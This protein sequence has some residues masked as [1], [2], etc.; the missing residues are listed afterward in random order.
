MVKE[1][2]TEEVSSEVGNSLVCSNKIMFSFIRNC[3]IPGAPG[4]L[5]WLSVPLNFNSGHDL[6]VRGIEL[7]IWLC[8]E[9]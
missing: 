7:N 9:V 8:A 2:L 4:R 5:S 3:H 6:E 1:G